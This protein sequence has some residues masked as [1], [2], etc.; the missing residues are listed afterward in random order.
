MQTNLR[1]TVD[2]LGIAL[3]FLQ[4]LAV[5][6]PFKTVARCFLGSCGLANQLSPA[7]AHLFR[8]IRQAASTQSAMVR[9]LTTLGRRPALQ[10]PAPSLLVGKNNHNLT[11][12]C[13]FS[14]AGDGSEED[15]SEPQWFT[16]YWEEA[17]TAA[18][19]LQ[20]AAANQ[21]KALSAL[22]GTVGIMAEAQLMAHF[23]H[24]VENY[25]G[26]KCRQPKKYTNGQLFTTIDQIL[27]FYGGRWGT[28][29]NKG[30][31]VMK[32]IAV[33][34][35][36]QSFSAFLPV[37]LKAATKRILAHINENQGRVVPD[38]VDVAET[39]HQL[40]SM[41]KRRGMEEAA[42]LARHFQDMIGKYLNHDVRRTFQRFVYTCINGQ[43][44]VADTNG[45]AL[46]AVMWEVARHQKVAP[47]VSGQ[48]EINAAGGVL[49]E[50]EDRWLVMGESKSS[51]TD[52]DAAILQLRISAHAVKYVLEACGGPCLHPLG[53]ILLLSRVE[54]TSKETVG[55]MKF[56]IR[57]LRPDPM[58]HD[59]D[60]DGDDDDGGREGE[61]RQPHSW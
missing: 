44:E 5:D 7:F 28:P 26:M 57:Q 25:T 29:T 18:A 53:I 12:S 37:A 43:A 3:S 45:A 55:D 49:F 1:F 9:S 51:S 59:S 47:N 34:A 58:F 22:V 36:R 14:S 46:S 48:L 2:A 39:Y 50:A 4:H 54:A 56:A 11:P 31:L 33:D 21:Q 10:G 41:L 13:S 23:V 35:I 30:A 6:L 19:N 15:D 8:V 24:E 32:L 52:K 38:L 61:A 17:R 16:R 42:G 27:E 40:R 20:K 60:D